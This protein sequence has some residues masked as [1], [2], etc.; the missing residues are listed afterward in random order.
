ARSVSA[1]SFACVCKRM[2]VSVCRLSY[3]LRSRIRYSLFLQHHSFSKFISKRRSLLYCVRA[4]RCCCSEHPCKR[5]SCEVVPQHHTGHVLLVSREGVICCH[6]VY[7]LLPAE[8]MSYTALQYRPHQ[9][10]EN[11]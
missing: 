1:L 10:V 9:Q 2:L 6:C 7:L 11:S 3:R 8:V 5:A 4:E